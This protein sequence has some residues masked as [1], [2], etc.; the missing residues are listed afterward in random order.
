MSEQDMLT[1]PAAWD[2]IHDWLDDNAPSL[3]KQLNDPASQQAIDQLEKTIG[4][5]F[6]DFKISPD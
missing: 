3:R 6:D 5:H 2:C 4:L 1:V